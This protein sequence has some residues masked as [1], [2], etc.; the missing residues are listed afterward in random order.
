MNASQNN[1]EH[2]LLL[3]H[4]VTKRQ[5][6]SWLTRNNARNKYSNHYRLEV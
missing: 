1:V 3:K 4:F 2:F 6:N 5:A